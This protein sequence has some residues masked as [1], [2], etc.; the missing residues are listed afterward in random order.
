MMAQR[1]TSAARSLIFCSRAMQA[2]HVVCRT[3]VPLFGI[4]GTFLFYFI[5]RFWYHR[6]LVGT[7]KLALVASLR[8]PLGVLNV[9][10]PGIEREFLVQ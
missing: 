6:L 7:V 10:V 4:L 3:L 9:Q 8:S 2:L 5:D 1:L